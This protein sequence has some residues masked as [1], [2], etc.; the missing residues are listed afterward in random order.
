MKKHKTENKMI[1]ERL[2]VGTEDPRWLEL[3]DDVLRELPDNLRR[4]IELRR[5][6]V[7]VHPWVDPVAAAFAREG[8]NPVTRQTYHTWLK[9]IIGV[10]GRE[11]ARRGLI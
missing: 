10:M 11:A 3:F 4:F 1:E 8:F 5:E 7:G 9:T 6:F 2:V